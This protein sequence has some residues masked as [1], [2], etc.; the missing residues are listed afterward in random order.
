MNIKRDDMVKVLSGKDKGKK[1]K[2]LQVFP[3]E[4]L[5]VVEG[6]NAMYK[7]MK[8][9]RSGESGQKIEFNGPMNVS[10]VMRIC[11]KCGKPARVGYKTVDSKKVRVCKKCGEAA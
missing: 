5:I 1:G 2:V 4:G 3:K 10:N 7:H 11:P 8:S 9:G 6:M